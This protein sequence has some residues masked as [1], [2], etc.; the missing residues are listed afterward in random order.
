MGSARQFF[1]EPREVKLQ[2]LYR[3]RIIPI[4]LIMPTA[5]LGPSVFRW[6]WERDLRDQMLNT[7]IGH[8]PRVSRRELDTVDAVE[9][10]WSWKT[11]EEGH[12]KFN[13]KDRMSCLKKTLKF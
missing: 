7:T 10:Q 4:L 3:F 12:E 8:S 5:G 6:R 11:R 1:T 2:V 9:G 13:L